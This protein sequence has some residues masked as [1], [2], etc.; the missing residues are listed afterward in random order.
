MCNVASCSHPSASRTL[1]LGQLLHVCVLFKIDIML[2][3]HIIC[4]IDKFKF[5][6]ES[7]YRKVPGQ[8]SFQAHKKASKL[9]SCTAV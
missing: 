5:P 6:V 3:Y 8:K 1:V 4:I 2:R 9:I 7:I